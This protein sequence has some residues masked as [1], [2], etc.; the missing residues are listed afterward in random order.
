MAKKNKLAAIAAMKCPR[1]REGNMFYA[2]ITQGIYKMNTECPVCKQ[3]FELEPGF[4]WGAMY[5][6]Y[7]LS[8]GY[9]LTTV[10]AMLLLLNWSV[11]AAFAVSIIGGIII[12]PFIAR[13]ARV[14]WINIYVAYDKNYAEKLN[15][16]ASKNV[17]TTLGDK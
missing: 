4:Y 15:K 8:G 5:V 10:G 3:P 1:C 16:A 2:P 17:K 9:M 13:L 14:I 11:E 6:G 7:G 12:F